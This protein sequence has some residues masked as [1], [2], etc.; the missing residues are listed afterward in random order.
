[1]MTTTIRPGCAAPSSVLRAPES[2]DGGPLRPM[3]KRRMRDLGPGYTSEVDTVAEPDWYQRLQEFNDANIYQTWAYAE[4]TWGLHNT[5]HLVLK[6]DGDVV[7]LAQVRI[8]TTPFLNIGI[9]Y[10]RWGPIWRRCS[11][12]AGDDV[13]RQAVRALRNEFTCKRGLVLRLFPVLFDDD[14]RCYST[15]LTE[16]G[17]SALGGASTSRTILMDLSPSIDDLREGMM[18]HWKR[19]LK[20]AERKPLE[21]IEGDEDGLFAAFIKTY[22]EMV[23]RKNFVEPNDIN[24]FRLIQARLPQEFK[25]RVMLCKSGDDICAGLIC[26]AIGNCAV[27]LFGATS[28]RG[29]KSRGSY[30][31]QWKLL[32]WL[33]KRSVATYNLNGINPTVNP[34]TYKFKSDLA[35]KGGK[36]VY[37]FGRFDSSPNGMSSL[38]VAYG[39]RLQRMR[40]KTKALLVRVARRR[41][42]T[43]AIGSGDGNS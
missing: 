7:A 1:M 22:T 16:E 23:S 13:F 20:T 11:S 30:L 8:V 4:V 39:E 14:P 40:S 43:K 31:L 35:A 17:F 28:D 32:G 26:S 42:Q 15:I 33:K 38:C 2:L 18:P 34:G 41:Q 27:Y 3:T 25:M 12:E 6:K 21:V 24:K 10:V 36:D 5:S 19:E 29:M 37:Y 9:A